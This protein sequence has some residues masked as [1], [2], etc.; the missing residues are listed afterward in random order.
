MKSLLKSLLFVAA[1]TLLALPALVPSAQAQQYE[2]KTLA[3][4]NHFVTATTNTSSAVTGAVYTATK[5]D[6]IGLLI[7][8]RLDGA[9]T[10]SIV[11]KFY[12]SLDGTTYDDTA[13]STITMTAN[14]TNLVSSVT[15]LDLGAVGYLRLGYLANPS[16]SGITN[17]IIKV[18]EKPKRQG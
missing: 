13:V 12:E 10:D 3:I 4:T 1:L 17:L 2:V 6:K 11:F 15:P 9:G 18:A 8:F 7:S 16:S 14:G 5:H